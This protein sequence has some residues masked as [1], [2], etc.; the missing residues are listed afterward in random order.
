MAGWRVCRR[1][2]H[3]YGDVPHERAGQRMGD[4]FL[5]DRGM[6]PGGFDVHFPGQIQEGP[7]R[8]RRGLRPRLYLLVG[9][10]ASVTNWRL[11]TAR[12][13]AFPGLPA[14]RTAERM[15]PEFKHGTISRPTP[16]F[17]NRNTNSS[18]SSAREEKTNSTTPKKRSQKN[19]K[20]GKAPSDII[21]WSSK[22]KC[23]PGNRKSTLTWSTGLSQR[24]KWTGD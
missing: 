8:G 15:R 9:Q 5:L 2:P 13:T 17:W 19:L 11:P 10:H 7:G 21:P 14:K 18:R 24:H 4:W 22:I 12:R 1:G 3:V 20:R 23:I 16:R 6:Q